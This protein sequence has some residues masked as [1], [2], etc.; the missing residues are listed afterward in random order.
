MG[1][2]VRGRIASAPVISVASL[3]RSVVIS[4][5]CDACYRVQHCSESSIRLRPKNNN[6]AAICPRGPME[7]LMIPFTP[8]Y[9]VLTICAVVTALL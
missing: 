6:A 8:R 4:V 3:K 2:A 9:I 1:V 5:T 7:T